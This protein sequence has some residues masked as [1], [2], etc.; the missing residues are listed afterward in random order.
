MDH[1]HQAVSERAVDVTV[2]KEQGGIEMPRDGCAEGVIEVKLIEAFTKS[3][4]V[5]GGERA[6][7]VEQLDRAEAILEIGERDLLGE[8]GQDGEHTG[9]R[10]IKDAGG[11]REVRKKA[12]RHGNDDEVDVREVGVGDIGIAGVRVPK[13]GIKS[14]KDIVGKRGDSEREIVR[15]RDEKDVR[16]IGGQIATASEI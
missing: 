5:V 9:A 4:R 1:A 6:A 13:C 8:D 10:H 3:A 7:A 2:A 11:V 12:L 16:F 15:M 14:R